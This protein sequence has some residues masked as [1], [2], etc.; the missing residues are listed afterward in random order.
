LVPFFRAPI[1]PHGRY[2]LTP[3]P[4]KERH[5][6]Q[7]QNNNNPIS[8]FLKFAI[9][10]QKKNWAIKPRSLKSFPKKAQLFF[11]DPHAP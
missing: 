3:P 11:R 6:P 5:V 7:K 9:I 2:P 4:L 1:A 8:F 10:E